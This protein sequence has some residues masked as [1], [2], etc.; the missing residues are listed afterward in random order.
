MDL[1]NRERNDKSGLYRSG[2]A[3]DCN[4]GR[5]RNFGGFNYPGIKAESI[6]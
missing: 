5:N 3:L 2:I 1:S 4:N 6:K